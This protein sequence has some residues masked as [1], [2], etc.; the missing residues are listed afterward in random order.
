MRE[1]KGTKKGKGSSLIAR[2]LLMAM[3][4][5]ILMVGVAIYAVQSTGTATA[6]QMAEQ[7]LFTSSLAVQME[8]DALAPTGEFTMKGEK[9]YRRGTSID[10]NMATFN[11]FV[12]QT[13]LVLMFY[14]QDTCLISTL[15]DETGA[16]LLTVT[17][18]QSV[19]DKVYGKAEH[20]FASD[21]EINGV[22]YFGYYYPL[23]DRVN[24]KNA[25]AL[26]FVGR[27]R[28]EMISIYQEQIT[29]NILLMGLL[30]AVS[31]VAMFFLLKA[32]T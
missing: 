1:T 12:L 6:N 17:L 13:D 31:A 19:K 27:E 14:Y 7:E 4:P 9:L 24:A 30:F 11:S 16:E 15:D 5:L 29:K 18:P 21:V 22:S 26:V 23:I 28:S 32:I 8:L 20:Y 25:N 10:D 2:I 3:I